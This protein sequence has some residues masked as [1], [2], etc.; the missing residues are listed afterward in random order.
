MT[1]V[2]SRL[3]Q[4]CCAVMGAQAVKQVVQENASWCWVR[5]QPANM[6][7]LCLLVAKLGHRRTKF[8]TVPVLYANGDL[9]HIQLHVFLLESPELSAWLEADHEA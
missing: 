6:I 7:D 1:R 2:E 3:E 4:F 5:L 9:D 8:E